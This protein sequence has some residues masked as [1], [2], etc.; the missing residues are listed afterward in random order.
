MK[1]RADEKRQLMVV[2]TRAYAAA[3]STDDEFVHEWGYDARRK[4]DWNRYQWEREHPDVLLLVIHGCNEIP[5]AEAIQSAFAEKEP[6]EIADLARIRLF[7]HSLKT[8]QQPT[9]EAI[10]K[11][12]GTLT[13]TVAYHSEG[14]TGVEGLS[15]ILEEGEEDGTFDQSLREAVTS[16]AT[17]RRMFAAK[18]HEMSS[19]LLRMRLLF[20]AVASSAFSQEAERQQGRVESLFVDNKRWKK[21][22][23]AL[24][25]GRHGTPVKEAITELKLLAS[26]G[27]SAIWDAYYSDVDWAEEHVNDAFAVRRR[28]TSF[29]RAADVI[30]HALEDLPVKLSEEG[31][32]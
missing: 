1:Q 11:P 14:S 27:D 32:P 8:R 19:G 6:L 15:R 5:P 23:Q 16:A 25:K 22:I 30:M 3:D 28:F 20:D 24:K 4:G 10:R 29:A 18:L 9:E 12:G 13:E 17:G 31:V 2:V 7:H 21:W 26:P